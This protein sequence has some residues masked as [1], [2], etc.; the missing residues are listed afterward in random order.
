MNKF[1]TKGRIKKSIMRLEEL[2]G[3]GEIDIQKTGEV[4]KDVFIDILIEEKEFIDKQLMKL[5]RHHMKGWASK[6]VD[7]FHQVLEEEMLK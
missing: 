5:F 3:R 4:I 7:L 2:Y 6:V 1:I